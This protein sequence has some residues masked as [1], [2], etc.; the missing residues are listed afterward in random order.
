MGTSFKELSFFKKVIAI[1]AI[2]LGVLVFGVLTIAGLSA[3]G[4]IGDFSTSNLD[5]ESGRKYEFNSMS[6]SIA[7]S[8]EGS[9]LGAKS[10]EVLA[11]DASVDIDTRDV[12]QTVDE[13]KA[14][15]KARDAIYESSRASDDGY[16]YISFKVA[17]DDLD[18]FVAALKEKYD[19]VGYSQN[20][21]NVATDYENID[22]RIAYLKEELESYESMMK[23]AVKNGGEYEAW[24]ADEVSRIREELWSLER[25]KD[26]LD[27]SVVHSDLYINISDS[28]YTTFRTFDGVWYAVKAGA[29]AFVLGLVYGVYALLYAFVMIGLVKIMRRFFKKSKDKIISKGVNDGK[30]Q[31]E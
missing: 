21:D 9:S 23:D 7:Q 22:E 25:S 29:H 6:D 8:Y 30:G 31:D 4:G 26:G 13:I 17:A 24:L 3:V 27:E 19:V 1:F 5:Y 14:M 11:K 15:G 2:A 10:N 18:D 12:M 20:T 28:S 16:G